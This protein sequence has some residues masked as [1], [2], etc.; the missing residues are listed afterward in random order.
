MNP[1]QKVGVFVARCAGLYFAAAGISGILYSC[2][3]MSVRFDLSWIFDPNWLAPVLHHGLWA[4]AG[5]AVAWFSVPIG[6]F[7]GRGLE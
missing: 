1:L 6:V 2:L 7:L 3:T 5:I 4:A